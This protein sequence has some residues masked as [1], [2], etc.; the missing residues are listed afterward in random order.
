LNILTSRLNTSDAN[1]LLTQDIKDLHP[2]Y[3][4]SVGK[5]GQKFTQSHRLRIGLAR[6]VIRNPN[7]LL[8]DDQTLDLEDYK[9]SVALFKCIPN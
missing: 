2:S 1:E 3:N 9:L 6:A 4:V 7:V 8:I 5:T